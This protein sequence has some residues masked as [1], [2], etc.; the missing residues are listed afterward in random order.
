MATA[1]KRVHGFFTHGLWSIDTDSLGR[2]KKSLVRALRLIFI[3]T[4]ET[5]QGELNLR[6]MSLVYTTLLSIVPLLAVSFSVLKSFGAH[7]VAEPMLNRFLA[8]LG[9]QGTEITRM[10]IGFVDKMKVGVL[11]SVGLALLMYTVISVIYKM[12]G[13]LNFI[14]RVSK[15]RTL[16][17]RF[18]D[19]MSVLLIGPILIFSAMGLTGAVK[20]NAF[21]VKL[22]S[23]GPAG[24]VFY[25]ISN[26]LPFIMTCAAFTFV[27]AFMPSTKVKVRPALVGG[28][29]AGLLWEASGWA[30][31]SFV[32]SST[33]YSAIYSGFAI[34][35]LF[36]I[37]LYWSW[38]VFLAGAAVSFYAQHPE[39][40]TLTKE[41]SLSGRLREK[42]A[43]SIMYL[44]GYN[45]YH[46]KPPWTLET[47][48]GR[49]RL[50]AEAVEELLAALCR[51][52]LLLKT[53]DE[54]PGYVPA[55]DTETIT[56]G[57]VVD[58]ARSSGE[59]PRVMDKKLTSVPEVEMVA[60]KIEGAVSGALKGGTIKGLVLSVRKD[61][62]A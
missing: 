10:V 27:Y 4:R 42:T 31:A 7:N 3:V 18:S 50:P 29:C 13:S 38:L 43:L 46:D 12:E 24:M 59:E 32:A 47:L 53:S 2:L 6:A 5:T 34:V 11:G 36:M 25:V 60:G 49:L 16:A 8:P 40:L 17:R 57:E 58:L 62:A 55:R 1:L 28:L 14:W 22:L 51:N 15:P 54:P 45:H 41:G 44:A 39:L 52:R 21:V 56:L 26:L 19:Y 23:L 33:Q 30:F 9:P 20:S 48:A 61:V 37:W 35:V